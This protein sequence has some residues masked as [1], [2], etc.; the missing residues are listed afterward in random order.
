LVA[1]ALGVF[2]ATFHGGAS[3]HADGQ[4]VAFGRTLAPNTQ[5]F[6]PLPA[7]GEIQQIAQLR[8]SGRQS[9]AD[10]IQQVIETPQAVWFTG[11]DP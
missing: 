9:D 7:H 8:S 3:A 11:G 6:V 4:T 2:A 1:A 10:L 5:F